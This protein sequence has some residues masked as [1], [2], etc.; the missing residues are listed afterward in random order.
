MPPP[1]KSDHFS[2]APRGAFWETRS[3][4]QIMFTPMRCL[5]AAWARALAS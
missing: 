2:L 3:C 4:Y 5:G 1:Q